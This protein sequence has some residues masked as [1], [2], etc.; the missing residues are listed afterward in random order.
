MPAELYELFPDGMV[1][2]ELGEI[3][4]GWEVKGVKLLR[5]NRYW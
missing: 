1:D 2:S 4:E 5:R 3:P